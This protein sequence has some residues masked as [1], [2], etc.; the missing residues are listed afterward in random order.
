M[1]SWYSKV[2]F[3]A[4]T[5]LVSALLFFKFAPSFPIASVVT[6]KQ[7]EF[8]VIGTGKVS[9][10]PDTGEISLGVTSTK[11]TVK[12][13]QT[14][15]NQK[16]NDITAALKK[17][18]VDVKDIKTENY[19]VYPQYDYSAGRSRISGYQVTTSVVVTVRDLD[20][21]NEVIDSATGLGANQIGGIN[22]TVADDRKK[23][24]ENSARELAVKDAKTKAEN[25]A[26]SAGIRLGKILNIQESSPQEPRPVYMA[27]DKAVGLG[28]GGDTSVAPGSTD[29]VS[30]ITLT[31]E[32]R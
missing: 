9:V 30:N 19:S 7:T 25:L 20:K 3:I 2:V 16:I 29:I 15:V 14:E 1:E 26:S 31:Y 21:I 11:N 10:I 12:P 13:A 23:E 8:W 5:G 24:L 22:F 32:T 18:G 6:Q 17:L 4:F 27:A 28:G